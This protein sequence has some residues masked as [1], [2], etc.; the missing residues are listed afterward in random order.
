MNARK[1][2]VALAFF[3]LSEASRG[4]F[5]DNFSDGDFTRNPA[6]VGDQSK[7]IVNA[8]KL[9]LQSPAIAETAFLATPSQAIHNGS[10]EFY[11]QFDFNPSSS[12]FAKIYLVSDQ[13][14]MNSALNGYFIKTGNTSRDVSLYRQSGTV[15]TK[16]IDGLDDRLNLSNVKVKIKIT[17]SIAGVWQLFTDVGPTGVFIEEGT[18]TDNTYTTASYFGVHCTYSATRADK[19]WF[20]DFVVVGVPVPDTTPPTLLSASAVGPYQI[21]LLFSELLSPSS[22]QIS[23]FSMQNLGPP[24][25]TSLLPDQK[26]VR[27]SLSVGLTN[28]VSYTLQISGVKDLAGNVMVPVT[29]TA[30]YF[31]AVSSKKKDIIFNEIFPDPAP[32]IG[33]PN[34]EFIEIYNRSQTPFNL[35]GWKLSDGNSTGT[36]PTQIV[37]PGEY[38]VVTAPSA[39][40]LFPNNTWTI[41][42]T[43]FPTLNNDGETLTLK[44]SNNQVIDSLHYSL[45]WYRDV[46]KQEGGWTLELIDPNNPCG[47]QDNWTASEDLKG[48]TPGKKNSV[49]ADKPDRTRP[50]LRSVFPDLS[51]AIIVSFDEK[52]D[53]MSLALSDFSMT[54]PLTISK[55]SFK[56]NTLATI[57][58]TVQSLMPREKYTL[59]I[60]NILDCNGNEME[61]SS[62]EFG[63]PEKADSLDV[64]INEILFNPRPG[65]SDFVE[66]HN[67][68]SKFLNMKNWKLG[69]NDNE[70]PTNLVNL[71]SE[72]F[73]F[74][75]HGFVVLTS[76]PTLLKLQYS[77]GVEMNFHKTLLPGL[78]DDKGSII[79]LNEE[80]QKID[81]LSYAKDWHSEF[82]KNEEGVSLERISTEAATND[83][84]NW[85]SASARSGFATP[86][87]SNS[88]FRTE[89]QPDEGDVIIDPEIF[90]PGTASADFVRIQYHFERGDWVG[91]V[92]IYDQ[93]A[94]LLKTI[95]NNETLGTAGFFRWDGDRD[96]GSKAR[97]GYYFVWFEIFNSFGSVMTFRK[98]VL[99]ASH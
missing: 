96:D 11:L 22:Q 47:E 87:F 10:W 76:D 27:L 4:Q 14:N 13:P 78:P 67:R 79:L 75:P 54:P 23:N 61:A 99:V 33:L 29:T 5:A 26:T 50:L 69:N 36:F 98:R 70:V 65:G 46:D 31:K 52:L 38:W 49:L 1:I 25:S 85:T 63:L 3:L 40:A 82:I 62:R 21:D 9:K 6:W 83:R 71:F 32:Q 77:Q 88:Q 48:G 42:M 37:L 59:E 93:Q 19:F 2:I 95:S 16:L 89:E 80:G 94:H 17:R 35:A 56:D 81:E 91:N 44:N 15:E 57:S 90:F 53:P 92:K 64:M 55:A 60:R 34:A 45:E 66:V 39:V 84:N 18:F 30:L 51:T 68:T 12:N 86:G 41:G 28:G 73:L 7:F 8:G 72:D 20:D 97:M 24:E 43:N 74:P 58:L